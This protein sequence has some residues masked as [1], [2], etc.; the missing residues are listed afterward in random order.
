MRFVRIGTIYLNLDAITYVE[1]AQ[2]SDGE[3]C[4]VVHFIGIPHHP[5]RPTESVVV[6][7]LLFYGG[8]A[9]R[10]QQILE[11]GGYG[12]GWPAEDG[13]SAPAWSQERPQ[14]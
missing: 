3:L 4:L 12:E 14:A 11:L 2:Q 9:S 8:H 7:R 10:L 6:D 1:T 13:R 5:G